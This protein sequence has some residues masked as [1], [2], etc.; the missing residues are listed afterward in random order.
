MTFETMTDT[1]RWNVVIHEVYKKLSKKEN[2]L[3]EIKEIFPRTLE[4]EDKIDDKAQEVIDLK[5]AIRTL[6]NIS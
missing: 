2:E 4:V 1:E 5:D 3:D 6:E